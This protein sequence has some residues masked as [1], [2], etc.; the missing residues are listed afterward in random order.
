MAKFLKKGALIALDGRIQSR[1]YKTQDGSNRE[2]IEVVAE[3][4]TFLESANARTG[5]VASKPAAV[6]TVD[7]DRE[8]GFTT[9]VEVS[10]DDLP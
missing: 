9:T 8:L 6:E 10:N 3:N 5:Q 7:L 4:V 2:T 1:R